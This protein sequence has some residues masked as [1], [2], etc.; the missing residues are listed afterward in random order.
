MLCP[1][2]RHPRNEPGSIFIALFLQVFIA[3]D[4]IPT[5]AS[6]FSMLNSIISLGL[7]L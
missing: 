3:I 4:K 1:V 6:P 2:T 7:S 5:Q